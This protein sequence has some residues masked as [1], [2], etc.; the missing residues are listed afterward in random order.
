MKR[1]IRAVGWFLLLAGLVAAAV[2]IERGEMRAEDIRAADGAPVHVIDGDSLRIGDREIRLAGIDAPEYRQSCDD[3]AGRPW[4]CGKAARE[5][6]VKLAAAGGLHCTGR[7]TD[8]FGR[9]LAD[10]RT[11]AG[12]LASALAAAGHALGARDERFDSRARETAAAR[13][14][15]RGIWRGAH[16]HPADWRKANQG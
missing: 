4:P 8:R 11:A 12:D 9:T 13:K 15:R 2:W 16:Q 7:A 14:A 1:R 5:A 6:L 10:C 3:E